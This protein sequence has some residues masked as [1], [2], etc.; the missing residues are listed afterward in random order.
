MRIFGIGCSHGEWKPVGF[1]YVECGKCGKTFCK[2]EINHP[3]RMALENKMVEAGFWDA[4][5]LEARKRRGTSMF[6]RAD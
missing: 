3:L 6:H 1:S 4:A 2:P 5:A